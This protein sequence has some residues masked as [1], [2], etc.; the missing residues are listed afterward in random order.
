MEV[1]LPADPVAL[2]FPS[3]KMNEAEL[4]ALEKWCAKIPAR[5][6]YTPSYILR[7]LHWDRLGLSGLDT[8]TLARLDALNP[9]YF[10]ERQAQALDST[11]RIAGMG[12]MASK[13]M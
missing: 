11:T 6:V 10:A 13:R 4:T 9:A 12:N 8:D 5:V 7:P 3:A 2:F 1:D